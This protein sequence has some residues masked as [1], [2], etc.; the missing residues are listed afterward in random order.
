MSNIFNLLFQKS[1]YL[2]VS[3]SV[4]TQNI[5][6][7]Q[8]PGYQAQGVEPFDNVLGRIKPMTISHPK[9]M[10]LPAVS[11]MPRI[12]PIPGQTS[13]LSSNSVNLYRSLNRFSQNQYDQGGIVNILQSLG[14]TFRKALLRS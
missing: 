12:M 11:N 9:H 14:Q 2:D 10:P 3:S 6:N 8:R 5:A 1:Q 7:I 4:E 13:T